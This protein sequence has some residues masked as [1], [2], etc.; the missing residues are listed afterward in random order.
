MTL[1]R[2]SC[3]S[4]SRGSSSSSS[5]PTSSP[6]SST[7]ACRRRSTSSSP[8]TNMAQQ[9]RARRRAGEE[10]P[11]D[12]GRGRR[13]RAPALRR[14]RGQPADGPHAAAA[15]GPVGAQRRPERAGVAVGQLAD[16]AGVLAQP[17]ERRRLPD[18]GAGAAVP[19]RLARFA[20]QRAGRRRRAARRRR[21][22]TQLLGNLV[23]A[24]PNRQPAV[25]SRYNI[26]PAVD[27]YASVQGTD[28]ASVATKVQ[29]LV[30][31]VKPKLPRGSQVTLRGQVETMQTSFVGL[32]IGLAMA[33]VLV[34]LLVVVNFQSWIDAVIIITALPAALGRHRLDAVHHRHHAVGAGADRRDHDHGRRH[35][36]QHPAGLVRPA[37]A[38]RGRRAAAARRSTPARPGS[39]RC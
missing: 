19:R 6:R 10:D 38:R 27:V 8:A 22:T 30:D 21:R 31:E 14:A 17:A 28:L 34:Y 4:A 29:A 3:R 11:A 2:A 26:T 20:A 37:A 33:I 13:A 35:R 16:G 32:G 5:R 12:P 1:L 7:S 36:E 25:V 9:R 15:D 39:G 18:R 23:E 24:T